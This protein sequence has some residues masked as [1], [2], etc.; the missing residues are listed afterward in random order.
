[1]GWICVSSLPQKFESRTCQWMCKS[2]CTGCHW[3]QSRSRRKATPVAWSGNPSNV[4]NHFAELETPS[5]DH[6][7][8][9][10]VWNFEQPY[11]CHTV[12][13]PVAAATVGSKP[14]IADAF[15]NK[16]WFKLNF[17][18]KPNRNCIDP[19]CMCAWCCR[20]ETPYIN[21]YVEYIILGMRACVRM[22]FLVCVCGSFWSEPFSSQTKFA[23]QPIRVESMKIRIHNTA[24]C[25]TL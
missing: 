24:N 2:F 9:L 17:D 13:A 14:K 20:N 12:A 7:N 5:V 8:P 15:R 3:A 23:I 22:R 10:V 18:Q 6:V 19:E 21:A 4:P 1:M 25:K 16:R 11:G